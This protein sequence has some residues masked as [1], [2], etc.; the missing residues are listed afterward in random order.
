M[1]ERPTLSRAI[2]D[3]ARQ[4]PEGAMRT[5]K[6]LLHL[7]GRAAVDQALSRLARRGELVRISRGLVNRH[8][9]GTPDRRPIG[10]LLPA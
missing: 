4:Q 6:A 8:G 7:G 9:T 2:L 5:A 3:Q 10:T 1:T